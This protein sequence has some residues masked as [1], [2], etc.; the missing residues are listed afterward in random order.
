MA[1]QNLTD[2]TSPRAA[3]RTLRRLT[4]VVFHIPSGQRRMGTL[5]F[6]ELDFDLEKPVTAPSQ[7]IPLSRESSLDSLQSNTKSKSRSLNMGLCW[8]VTLVG[9][10]M[11]AFTAALLVLVFI[12]RLPNSTTHPFG[13]STRVSSDRQSILVNY[14]ATRLTFIASWSSTLAPMLLGSL[15]ALWHIPTACKLAAS[16]V[17]NTASALPTPRQLSILIGLASGSLDELRKYFM[18]Q[19]AR[20]RAKQPQILTR[21]VLILV[22]S[23]IMTFLIFCADTAIHAFTSTVP[24]SRSQMQVQ[25]S[26]DFGRGLLGECINFDRE[27]NQG[28]P[29][30]VIADASVGANVIARNAGEVISLQRNVS[31]ENSIWTVQDEK[32]K[33]GDLLILMP[34]LANIPPDLDYRATTVGVSTQ[35]VPSSRRCD[36]RLTGGLGPETSYVVFNCTDHFRGVLGA[37]PSISNNTLVWTHTDSTTPDF[38]FKYDRNFQYA[39]FSDP[40]LD[41]IYNSIGGNATNDGASGELALPNAELIK[42]YLPSHCRFDPTSEWTAR[43]SSQRRQWG[44]LYWWCSGG[45]H[46]Q[47]LCDVLRCILQLDQW[48][49]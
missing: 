24:F 23:S 8:I 29:C 31:S 10:P 4:P 14:S 6:E 36:V 11:L 34:Q 27:T 21:S 22:I 3:A 2:M 15:M 26:R 20:V 5:H 44:R 30:T 38:N 45:L 37:D 49:H 28:L 25:L 7:S 1:T 18:Y 43:K 46:P 39:Y 40:G 12:Y 41:K 42:S 33:N 13:V 9:L 48:Y 47:L 16:T 35:C 19:S 17:H 32:L